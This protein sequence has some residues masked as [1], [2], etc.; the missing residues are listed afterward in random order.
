MNKTEK[1]FPFSH[2]VGFLLSIALTFLALIVALRT[3]LSETVVYTIISILAFFQAGLQ[4]FMFMHMSEGSEGWA[5]IIHTI[6][7]IFMAL[8]V[9]IGTIFVMTAGHP[10]H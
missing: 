8:V 2:I 3:S 1:G 4:L 5:K 6:Y 7:A 9:V 10:I